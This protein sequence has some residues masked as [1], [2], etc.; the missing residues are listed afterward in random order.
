MHASKCRPPRVLQERAPALCR[1]HLG[2]G[3][4]ARASASRGATSQL[5]HGCAW[6]RGLVLADEAAAAGE[7]AQEEEE[8]EEEEED[9]EE[10]YEARAWEV[11]QKEDAARGQAQGRGGGGGGGGGGA[12]A[13]G[14]GRGAAEGEGE[15]HEGAPSHVQP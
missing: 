5:P 2:T 7:E 10:G 8:E 15:G 9:E 1:H 4:A 3:G 6:P 14:R 12:A 13:A 11:L